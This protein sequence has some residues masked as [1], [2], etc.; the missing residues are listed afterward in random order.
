MLL[1]K[2]ALFHGGLRLL[3]VCTR[4]GNVCDAAYL[5]IF[6]ERMPQSIRDYV[7]AKQ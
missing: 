7:D 4:A 3:D 1:T 6:S 2:A 5:T